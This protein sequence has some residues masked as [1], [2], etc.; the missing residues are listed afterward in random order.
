MTKNDPTPP[1][2][3]CETT[4]E[5]LNIITKD[6]TIEQHENE[7]KITIEFERNQPVFSQ[8]LIEQ[9]KDDYS[10]YNTLGEVLEII[11]ERA[12]KYGSNETTVKSGL[13][14]TDE[15]ENT[16]WKYYDTK[17]TY[18]SYITDL[19]KL[20]H[21]NFDQWMEQ[22]NNDQQATIKKLRKQIEENVKLHGHGWQVAHKLAVKH[23]SEM[24]KQQRRNERRYDPRRYVK[25]RL[26]RTRNIDPRTASNIA[27][28]LERKGLLTDEITEED[29]E[30][31]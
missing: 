25:L 13:Y 22:Y 10:I 2:K 27:A 11:T 4:V 26:E 24:K 23:L 14:Y 3:Y 18:G 30:K 28:S 8:R 19:E 5:H 7:D 1:Y 15:N 12:N 29:L 16:T 9:E 21:E 20:T 6:L 31:L 17:N